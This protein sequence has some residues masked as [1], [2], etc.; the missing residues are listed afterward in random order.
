MIEVMLVIITLMSNLDVTENL[1]NCPD[2]IVDS[3][4]LKIH[5]EKNEYLFEDNIKV[6]GISPVNEN[7]KRV[8]IEF[9]CGG[10][11]YYSETVLPDMHG[12]FH[13]DYKL[14][15]ESC[16]NSITTHNIVAKYL[17][18][19]DKVSF[20]YTGIILSPSSQIEIP[21]WVKNNAGWWAAGKIDDDSFI[22]G[23]QHLIKDGIIKIN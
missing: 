12:K 15:P 9:Y 2:C 14:K 20:N 10:Q 3:L 7:D 4:N 19:T 18:W 22:Q 1:D 21:L 8:K 5:E 16:I 23:I 13:L 11:S 6:I 17:N